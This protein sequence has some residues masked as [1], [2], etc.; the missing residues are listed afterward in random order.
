MYTSE[1][2]STLEEHC[3][4][5]DQLRKYLP[6]AGGSNIP[7]LIDRSHY[8]ERDLSKIV[9]RLNGDKPGASVTKH[10][11]TAFEL[12]ASAGVGL[13]KLGFGGSSSTNDAIGLNYKTAISPMIAI[14]ADLLPNRNLRNITLRFELGFA[15]HT[16][17]GDWKGA[18]Y[19]IG[20]TQDKSY[21]MTFWDLSPSFSLL[22]N[23]RK[24][25]QTRYYAG[26]GTAYHFANYSK[27]TYTLT[28]ETDSYYNATD[29]HHFDLMSVWPSIF[30][31]AGV[32]IN[33]QFEIGVIGDIYGNMANAVGYSVRS[34]TYALKLAYFFH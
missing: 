3:I 32:R 2:V 28:D 4:Y 1:Y 25:K 7:V 31:R 27:N 17:Q 5:R 33:Q 9:Y 20:H 6:D 23:F 10:I 21:T 22:Y 24:T 19:I 30:L 15:R 18:G 13:S 16:Y 29:N 11:G 8:T 26:L 12:F 14:G 34:K